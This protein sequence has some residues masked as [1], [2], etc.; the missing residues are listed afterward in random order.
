MDL[1]IANFIRLNKVIVIWTAFGGLLY[2]FRDMFGLVFIT[3]I[4]C[5]VTYGLTAHR[6]RGRFPRRLLVVIFY[7]LFLTL[8]ISFLVF[9]FPRLLAEAKNFTEQLPATLQ[10][11]E[12]WLES[13][14]P[15]ESGLDP[16]VDRIRLMLT[17]EQL[18]IRGWAMGWGVVEKVL[19][20]TAWFFL[21]LL[22]SFLIMMDLPH[23]TRGIR[24]LRFTRAALV[25]EETVG[26]V[27]QFATVV[28][29]NFRA[30]IIISTV[31]TILT[32]IGIHILGIGNAVLLSTLVFFCGL[33][34]VLGVFISSVPIV[35]MAVNNGGV[36]L[37]LWA[38]IMITFIHMVEAYIL[39]PR[40]VS[41]V[42]RIN[43]VV[44]L[45]ILF[46]AHSLVG[47]WGMLL[48]VPCAVY[49]YRHVIH[50]GVKRENCPAPP[51][52]EAKEATCESSSATA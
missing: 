17:P 24:E 2:I 21:G 42:M 32:A 7:A 46:I 13:H 38:L 30:Q 1:S 18:I 37:G 23:L 5:F 50:G 31:N 28:G 3:F 15:E 22:F 6:H 9:F 16:V 44:T 11:I 41:R 26:S 40:I 36:S 10:T 14:V 39:N 52:A 47:L 45:I 19:H 25:Y 8:V 29:R 43:P 20:Y 51:P 27:I 35:L 4:M 49:I 34:P 48:G 33:I 12:K